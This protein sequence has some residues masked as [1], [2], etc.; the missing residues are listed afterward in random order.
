MNEELQ[1]RLVPRAA[2]NARP[3]TRPVDGFDAP[4]RGIAIHWTGSPGAANPHWPA[5]YDQMRGMQRYHQERR[6]WPDIGYNI[7]VC[8]HGFAFVG[9][10]WNLEPTAQGVAGNSTDENDDYFAV[11]WI[12]GH[13]DVPS[14]AAELTIGLVIDEATDLGFPR[15]LRP[16]SWFKS[17][18]CPGPDL[19]RLIAAGRWSSP[20]DPTPEPPAPPPPPPT[21][22]ADDVAILAAPSVTVDQL[23]RHATARGHTARFRELMVTVWARSLPLGV[24][25]AIP[26]A[27]ME[28]ETAGGR[29]GGV[30]TPEFHNWGGI[31]TTAGGDNSDPDAH[32]R[33]PD[34]G[35]GVLAVIQHAA[36]YAGLWI[37]PELVVDPRHF[38]SI[39][40]N[41]PTLLSA[42]WRWAGPD[43]GPN[44]AAKVHWL[45][46]A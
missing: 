37:P 10:G 19:H 35:T 36:L 27:I 41:A 29:F 34:D 16:H 28:H 40:G 42:G 3:K 32:Q 14:P 17:T 7:V 45:R 43:H 8:N 22:P 12:G 31:K 33:F 39:R 25:P 26:A 4:H 2:W 21:A 24:D 38:A 6:G 1:L 23:Q 15:T 44:V 20:A 9:R 11:S 46:L 18:T 5:C 30:L 13:G